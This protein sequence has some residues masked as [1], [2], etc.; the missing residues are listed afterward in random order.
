MGPKRDFWEF[1]ADMQNILYLSI[2][3][4]VGPPRSAS[5]GT[6]WSSPYSAACHW[7]TSPRA[8][9]SQREASCKWVGIFLHPGPSTPPNQLAGN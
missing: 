9:G 8:E 4:H 6:K 5:K 2:G 7:S 3:R 1:R